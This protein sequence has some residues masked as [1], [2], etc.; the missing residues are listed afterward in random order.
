MPVRLKDGEEAKY[1][2]L[3]NN[4]TQWLSDFVKKFLMPHSKFRIWTLRIR[5]FTSVGPSFE[6]RIEKGLQAEFLKE[7][8]RQ[9]HAPDPRP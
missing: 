6:S 4:E 1:F 9:L 7:V 3:L 5:V 8:E 2:I